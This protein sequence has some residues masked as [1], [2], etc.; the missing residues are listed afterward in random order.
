MGITVVVMAVEFIGGW[1][2]DSIAL[3]SD[4]VHML[5]H[6]I[7]LGIS[8]AG[9]LIARKL[10]CHHLSYTKTNLKLKIV[11]FTNRFWNFAH[12][13]LNIESLANNNFCRSVNFCKSFELCIDLFRIALQST[14][15]FFLRFSA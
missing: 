9:I 5:T 7:D 8:I 4:A 13:K 15:F 12:R 2:S 3:I 11:N 6:V 1:L 14:Q 10:A